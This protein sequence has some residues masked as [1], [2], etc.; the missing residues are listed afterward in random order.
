MTKL[1]AQLLSSKEPQFH[2]TLA[3]LEAAAGHASHDIRLSEDINQ[4]QRAKLQQLGLDPND[5]T[6]EELFQALQEKLKSDDA[7][8]IKRLR[9][10]S[11]YQVNA[12]ANL[13]EGIAAATNEV[14][15]GSL[16]FV[17]K[18]SVAKRALAK[19]PPKKVMKALNFR[20]YESMLKHVPIC[21]LLPVAQ[22]LEGSGWLQHYN[23]FLRTLRPRDFEER[24]V[25][26]YSPHTE[27]WLAL[28][29]QLLAISKQTVLVNKELGSIV[30][31]PLPNQPV[32]GI[33]TLTLAGAASGLNA[34]YAASSYFRL[35]QVA[36]DFGAR[37]AHSAGDEPQILSLD[38]FST[39]LSWET[40]VRF[41]HHM[42]GQLG[43][44]LDAHIGAEELIG[45]QP[46]EHLIQRIAPEMEFWRD[47]GHVGRLDGNGSDPVSFNVTDNALSLVNR[48]SYHERYVHHARR[49][50][51]QELIARY[52]RP[53]LLSAAVSAE[54]APKLATV[55]ADN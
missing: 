2:Q 16:I 23:T 40:V 54:L 47:C 32:P 34:I 50:L 11:A 31:L 28:K 3:R 14:M 49:A 48:K 1:L 30:I 55:N 7:L 33:A 45:W 24:N 25:S 52:I 41:I 8:L 26:V 18:S 51:W 22:E 36:K 29:S 6:G 37:I 19:F 27:K 17:L 21:L 42:Q 44:P 46:V 4:L 15:Q 35:S 53:D 20:S 10:I 13:S 12:A 38:Y 39:P 9:Q 5:T 43:N